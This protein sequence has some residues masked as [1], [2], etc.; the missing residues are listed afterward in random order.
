M[1]KF[2]TSVA[3]MTL[4]ASSS[5]FAA[6]TLEST[7]NHAHDNAYN[8]NQNTE[9]FVYLGGRG[10]IANFYG[11]LN[12]YSYDKATDPNNPQLV[13][14]EYSLSDSSTAWGAGFLGLGY[15]Y[16][17]IGVRGELEANFFESKNV[18]KGNL[19][20]IYGNPDNEKLKIQTYMG[21]LYADA[22]ATENS[23]FYLMA[24]FGNAHLE[25]H[26]EDRDH[27]AWQLGLGGQY[28]FISH[29]GAEIGLRYVDLGKISARGADLEPDALQ[30]YLGLIARF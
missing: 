2:I 24:G 26:D 4:V 28:Y 15:R 29:L 21:N 7:D 1:N 16:G 10:G 3:A 30:A 25:Y 5:G 19:F 18:A 12:A 17:R 8:V 22:Y 6:E 13:R 27:F 11:D 20:D 14:E 9:F 23:V